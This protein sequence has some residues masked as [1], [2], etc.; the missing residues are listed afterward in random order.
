[1]S[2]P[3]TSVTV[4]FSP[5]EGLGR[6]AD[7][8]AETPSE[9]AA[10]ARVVAKGAM[11]RRAPLPHFGKRMSTVFILRSKFDGLRVLGVYREFRQPCDGP[12]QPRHRAQ[13]LF[14]IEVPW[15]S[16]ICMSLRQVKVASVA[17]PSRGLQYI[18][19]PS[20]CADFSPT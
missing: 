16:N 3:D 4:D 18:D 19:R 12:G 5:N 15:V 13:S 8:A 1:M 7:E 2:G 17:C 9:V 10:T 11:Q 6:I 14:M 20:D